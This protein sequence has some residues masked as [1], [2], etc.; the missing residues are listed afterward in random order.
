MSSERKLK[1]PKLPKIPKILKKKKTPSVEMTTNR[2]EISNTV[3]E[4]DLEKKFAENLSLKDSYDLKDEKQENTASETKSGASIGTEFTSKPVANVEGDIENF[5]VRLGLNKFTKNKD[6]WKKFYVFAGSDFVW[7]QPPTDINERRLIFD[8]V[9]D[10]DWDPIGEELATNA[11]EYRR[12]LESDTLDP[13]QGTHILI[14]HGKFVRYGSSKE[15]K[16]MREDYPGCYYVPVKE[17]IVELRRFSASDANTNAGAEKE[18][19]VQGFRM[20][21]DTGA[22]TTV[23]PYFIRRKLY[24]AQDGWSPNPSR[25]DGYGA[26]AKMFQASRDWYICLGDGINWSGWVR[27]NE[28]HSWQSNPAGVTCGVI[29]YDVLNNIPHYKPCRQPY[30]FLKNDIFGQ[31]PQLQ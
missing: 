3:S 14:V 16:K 1:L 5:A 4:P 6:E 2:P 13:L 23:I 17:R 22:T 7:P 26:G 19:Q 30:V 11:L 25:A 12:L 15:E 8:Y 29:G 21:M 27:T 24:S 10:P 28:I 9:I 31:I 18:W 20:I